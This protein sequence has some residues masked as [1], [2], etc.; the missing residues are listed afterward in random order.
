MKQIFSFKMHGCEK[1]FV[2]VASLGN[3]LLSLEEETGLKFEPTGMQYDSFGCSYIRRNVQ[4]WQVFD[5][6]SLRKHIEFYKR[7]GASIHK[8]Y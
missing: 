6:S 8:K 3:H 4:D 2:L 7:C 5:M 1:P